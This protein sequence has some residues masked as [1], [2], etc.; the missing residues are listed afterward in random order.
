MTTPISFDTLSEIVYYSESSPSGLRWKV[1]KGGRAAKDSIAGCQRKDRYWA[2]QVN[3]VKYLVH[4]VIWCLHHKSIEDTLIINH[5]D[6]NPANNII[7]NLE[8]CSYFHN[9][10][11]TKMHTGTALRADNTSGI[12]GV[13]EMDNGTGALYATVIYRKNGLL[14]K[15]HFSYAKLGKEIAWNQAVSFKLAN[16]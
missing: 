2:I 16:T 1:Y 12:T 8:L 9:S 6:N 10:N 13:Y 15:K 11:T 7:T 5:I 4:R 3:S 14:S